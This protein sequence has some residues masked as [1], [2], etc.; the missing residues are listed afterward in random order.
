LHANAVAWREGRKTFDFT[1]QGAQYKKLPVVQY[2]VWCRERL[3]EHFAA[4]PTASRSAVE[5][6][7]RD[8]GALEPLMRDGVIKSHLHDT[9]TPPLCRPRKVALGDKLS[10]YLIGT[11]WHAPRATLLAK[12]T[13]SS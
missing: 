3:Q 11:H 2:R 9:D 5:N 6:I 7:L 10:R 12:K 8:A 1:V 13:R 4:V